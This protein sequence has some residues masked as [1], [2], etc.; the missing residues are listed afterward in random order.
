M[1]KGKWETILDAVVANG[2]SE[3]INVDAYERLV[4][5]VATADS[6][7]A[8]VKIV[9]SAQSAVPD[10]GAAASPSNIWAP[11]AMFDLD[12]GNA[13]PGSTGVA[14]SGTDTVKEYHLNTDALRWIGAIVSSY[15][16][17]TIT[18]KV[19]GLTISR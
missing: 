19:R 5:Q 15:V 10:F 6:T 11:K 2:D 16:A 1:V 8:T 3:P 17:G 4:V 7:N 9:G 12:N 13:V 14:L 18:V